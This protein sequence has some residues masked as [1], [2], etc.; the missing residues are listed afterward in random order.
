M[1]N[2]VS[3]DTR[4]EV[5]L[6]NGR[7]VSQPSS[8]YEYLF[9][10]KDNLSTDDYEEVLLSIMDNQYYNDSDPQIKAIVDTYFRFDK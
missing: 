3:F 6:L 7:L 5:E 9:L 10:C 2:V 1:G 8:K 4:K